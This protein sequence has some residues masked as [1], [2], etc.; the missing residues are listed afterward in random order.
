[1]PKYFEKYGRK[2]PKDETHTPH[3]FAYGM[4]ESTVWEVINQDP[5]RVIDFAQSM[6][7]LEQFLPITGMYDFS[8]IAEKAKESPDRVLFVD[9][10]GGKGQ[11]I[12]A[13]HKENPGIDLTRCVLEDR[14]EVIAEVQKLDSPELKGTKTIVHNFWNEQPVKGSLCVLETSNVLL[15]GLY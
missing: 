9:V 15:G 10:G 2:E 14:P 3:T 12:K 5:Q 6:N 1:M 11:A 7:T 4:P 13:I 8:W